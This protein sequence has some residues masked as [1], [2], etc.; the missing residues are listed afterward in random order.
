MLRDADSEP[1][2]APAQGRDVESP[3][4]LGGETDDEARFDAGRKPP[5]DYWDRLLVSSPTGLPTGRRTAVVSSDPAQRL[6]FVGLAAVVFMVAA[7]GLV[8][9][10]AL[11]ALG[12]YLMGDSIR[13]TAIVLGVFVFSMG[14]GSLL[15]KHRTNRPITTFV[16]IECALGLLGGLSVLLLY[17]SFAWLHLYM[18][19]LVLIA[20]LIGALI[21]A[22]LPLLATL[23]DGIRRRSTGETVADLFAL[24]YVG[25]LLGG[26]AFPFVLL[27]TVGLL[28]GTMLVGVVNVLCALALALVVFRYDL[29]RRARFT[30]IAGTLAVLALLGGGIWFADDFEVTARQA[31]FRDPVVRAERT[32]YQEIVITESPVG[33]RAG[34]VR[35]FLNGNLQF[36]S[37]DEHR[38]HE[39]LVHPAMRGSR[40]SVLILGGGDGL[41]LREVL[42]YPDVEAVTLVELD[43]QMIEMARTDARF[44]TLNRSSFADRRVEVVTLDA[45]TYIR[46]NARKFDVILIDFPDPDTPGNAKLFSVEFYGMLSRWIAPTSRVVLQASSPYFAP[47]VFWD[48]EVN[49]RAAGFNTTAFH[50][51]VPSF[52]DWGFHLATFDPAEIPGTPPLL[53][54][55][56]DRPA[57]RFLTPEVLTAGQAFPPDQRPTEVLQP[58]TLLQPHILDYQQRSWR[59]Y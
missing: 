51:D 37:I 48:I 55:P 28:T 34:D 16:A 33:G 38:Y 41:A 31:L 19:S 49:L 6:A 11:I 40:K 58:S 5:N 25:A 59:A 10:L 14:I 2:F 57:L 1:R 54:L 15:T 17:A 12:S 4:V 50:V 56:D 22:E 20:F 23:F 53:Q 18:P 24:D 3:L 21:G 7:C 32:P 13:Q 52:G 9:E 47:L 29:S 36:A 42:R 39:T 26:L 44:T 30:I 27:P 43:P 45:F 46:D 8:Y 35:M